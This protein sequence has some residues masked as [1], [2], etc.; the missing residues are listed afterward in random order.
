MAGKRKKADESEDEAVASESEEEK[1]KKK[2]AAPKEKKEKAKDKPAPKKSK[3]RSEQTRFSPLTGGAQK[4]D[5]EVRDTAVERR[6]GTRSDGLCAC[7]RRQRSVAAAVLHTLQLTLAYRATN[8]TSSL[9]RA[10]AAP[11]ARSKASALHLARFSRR[12]SDSYSHAGNVLIDI[13]EVR[14]LPVC[15]RAY[16]FIYMLSV[17]LRKGWRVSAGEEGYLPL[18]RRST[19]AT[20]AQAL[21]TH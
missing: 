9:A 13:R 6:P 18:R 19:S 10:S 17:V 15:V 11:C 2:K 14:H 3:V 4:E 12:Q 1:P 7:C 20:R 21:F 8:S 5:K 16:N